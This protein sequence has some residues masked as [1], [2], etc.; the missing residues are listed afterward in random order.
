MIY[1]VSR[2][3]GGWVRNQELCGGHQR[4]CLMGGAGG[5]RQSCLISLNVEP[6]QIDSFVFLTRLINLFSI[7]MFIDL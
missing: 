7:I 4:P 3:M 6:G 1:K 5:L 2:V